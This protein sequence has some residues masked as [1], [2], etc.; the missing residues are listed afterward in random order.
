M[1]FDFEDHDELYWNATG[2]EWDVPILNATASVTYPSAI[3]AK[4]VRATCFTGS[5]GD[6][7][8][9]CTFTST[10]NTIQYATNGGLDAF[11][12]LT[13]ATSLPKS[14]VTPPPVINQLFWFF[15]DNLPYL[16]PV[17]TF[18]LF[19]YLWFL[20]DNYFKCKIQLQMRSASL[21]VL[22]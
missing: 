5:Y 19:Y 9:D 6:T 12:G 14:Y 4:D 21:F 13:I 20:Y 7:N 8:Q 22:Y 11:E 17:F 10:G 18:I 1:L 15:T 16:L 3:P 2:D